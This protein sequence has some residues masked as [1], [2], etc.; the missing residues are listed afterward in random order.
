MPVTICIKCCLHVP[1]LCMQWRCHGRHEATLRYAGF[2]KKQQQQQ[3]QQ[4]QHVA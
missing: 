1:L 3:Q 4:Q 2:M